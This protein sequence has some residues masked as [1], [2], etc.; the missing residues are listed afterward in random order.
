MVKMIDS[1]NPIDLLTSSN[2]QED[3][4]DLWDGAVTYSIK[5]EAR[6]GSK[7]WVSVADNNIGNT[8]LNGS[9]K[10]VYDR[11]DNSTAWSDDYPSTISTNDGDDLV[12]EFEKVDFMK[13]L[14][15]DEVYGESVRI[16]LID[17]YSGE[18]TYDETIP[19][20]EV[21]EP[22]NYYEIRYM[23]S[24][25]YYGNSVFKTI[26]KAEYNQKLRVTVAKRDSK[27]SLGFLDFGED[28]T[29]GCRKINAVSFKNEAQ[30]DFVYFRNKVKPEVHPVVQSMSIEMTIFKDKKKIRSRVSNRIGLKNV[31]IVEPVGDIEGYFIVGYFQ[32]FNPSESY[33]SIANDFTLEVKKIENTTQGAN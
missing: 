20:V 17:N 30:G 14:V 13:L 26:G 9:L 15:V 21:E 31:V 19:L 2:I 7:I 33:A 8:P 25:P 28:F 5:D 6:F 1:F 22:Q 24:K 11:P 27:A 18:H 4:V 3:S 12:L 10:W 23:W 16:E 29:L 32:T